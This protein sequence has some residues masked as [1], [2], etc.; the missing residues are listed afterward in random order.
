M[1]RLTKKCTQPGSKGL[2]SPAQEGSGAAAPARLREQSFRP[3][4]FVEGSR[5]DEAP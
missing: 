1:M 5:A 2:S 4:R 3:S